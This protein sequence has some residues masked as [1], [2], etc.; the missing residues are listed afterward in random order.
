VKKIFFYKAKLTKKKLFCE[1]IIFPNIK[2]FNS[3]PRYKEIYLNSTNTFFLKNYEKKFLNELILKLN[4]IH[5]VNFNKKLWTILIGRW[6]KIF[7]H[8]IFFRIHYLKNIIKNNNINELH[9]SFDKKAISRPKTVLEFLSFLKSENI[10]N[11]ILYEISREIFK[12]NKKIKIFIR[13]KKTDVPYIFQKIKIT[14]KIKLLIIN[15][16]N[17]FLKFTLKKNSPI[18]VNTYLPKATEYLFLI[19]EN[20][21]FLWNVYFIKKFGEF[22]NFIPKKKFSINKKK[23]ILPIFNKKKLNEFERIVFSMSQFLFP[24][25]YLESFKA[26]RNFVKDESLVEEP[27]YVFTSNNFVYDDYFKFLLI[28]KMKNKKTRFIAGQHGANY[29][30]FKN[31]THSDTSERSTSDHFLTW[32]W[33][34]KKKDCPTLLF[35]SFKKKRKLNI[36]KID[37][38]IFINENFPNSIEVENSKRNFFFKLEKIVH[39]ILHMNKIKKYK[40]EIKNHIDDIYLKDFYK[41][42]FKKNLSNVDVKLTYSSKN[43]LDYNLKNSLVIFNYFSTGFLEMLSLKMN[44]LCIVNFNLNNFSKQSIAYIK[45]LVKNHFLFTEPESLK[46]Y[47][48]KINNLQNLNMYFKRK[49]S[50]ISA[51]IKYYANNDIKKIHVLEK[52]LNKDF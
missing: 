22:T 8:S 36:N 28:D 3:F 10:N 41:M 12:N 48:N 2:Y 1:W 45:I 4:T 40:F 27:K 33:K 14:K 46:K 52:I 43:I 26:C 19:K 15:S 16:I 23:T 42:Y 31:K 13:N 47:I 37:K 32:G 39:L 5:S 7:L 49:I 50:K 30:F 9:F 35:K 34:Y 6:T 24:M 20:Y 21:F 51:F 38:I 18:I 17:F 25:C 11:Y 29:G 44:C